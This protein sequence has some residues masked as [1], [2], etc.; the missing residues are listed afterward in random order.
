MTTH[1][2]GS[3][4]TEYTSGN[5]RPT[6]KSIRTFADIPASR[7]KYLWHGW[8]PIGS[9]TTLIGDPARYKSTLRDSIIARV[10]RGETLYGGRDTDLRGPHNVL[11]LSFEEDE[12]SIVKPR[13]EAA[14]ADVSRV[15]AAEVQHVAP[16]ELARIVRDYNIRL[17]AIDPL[18]SVIA[19]RIDTARDN[20]VRAMLDPMATMARDTGCAVLY[21]AHL[22]KR[23]ESRYIHRL[24]GSI[25]FAAAMRS[26]AAVEPDPD[27]AD[28]LVLLSVKSNAAKR[29]TSLRF[30]IDETDDEVPYVVWMGE[31]DLSAEDFEAGI[32]SQP[33]PT[34][35]PTRKDARDHAAAWLRGILANGP[36]PATEV[37]AAAKEHGI[38]D[39]QLN[40]AKEAMG[41]SIQ[42]VRS[43][44]T[45]HFVWS[46]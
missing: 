21:I 26:I 32:S 40:T 45:T 41:V 25:A 31:S 23:S 20:Q 15:F 12:S 43:S 34:A 18:S 6:P 3:S 4:R 38:S 1:R 8:L 33:R 37:K 24:P 36:R 46:L 16:D 9:L 2:N 10:T 11:L 17:V 5:P 7:P 44:G 35:R 14:G 22:T 42:Q 39:R 28:E 27:D 30:T 13:L 29:P 19:S